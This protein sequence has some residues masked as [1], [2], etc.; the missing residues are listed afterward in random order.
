MPTPF[1]P[2]PFVAQKQQNYA[3]MQAAVPT[4]HRHYLVGADP[5]G[6]PR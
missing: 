5:P 4:D 6:V 2:L 3:S 1:H